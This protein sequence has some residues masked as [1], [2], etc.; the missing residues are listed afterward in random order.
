MYVLVSMGARYDKLFYRANL[1]FPP[2]TIVYIYW[3][4]ERV[5]GDT[6]YLG[7]LVLG[8]CTI[9]LGTQVDATL[10]VLYW[11]A[12][13]GYTCGWL[14]LRLGWDAAGRRGLVTILGTQLDVTCRTGL[15]WSCTGLSPAAALGWSCWVLYTCACARLPL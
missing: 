2:D 14:S 13:S 5:E 10:L 3:Y 9:I 1:F 11:D 12:G 8:R 7:T 4:P 6:G 15:G